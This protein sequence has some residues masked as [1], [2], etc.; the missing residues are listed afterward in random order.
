MRERRENKETWRPADG[1]LGIVY[2]VE[3]PSPVKGSPDS[4]A[5]RRKEHTAWAAQTKRSGRKKNSGSTA[6]GQPR[7]REERRRGRDGRT[8]KNPFDSL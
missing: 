3:I 1:P 5:E 6:E 4:N 2:V 7:G 8:R